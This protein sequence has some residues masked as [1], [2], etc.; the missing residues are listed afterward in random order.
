MK[1]KMMKPLVV[2]GMALWIWGSVASPV[3]ATDLEVF[4]Y[5]PAGN[6]V[7][8]SSPFDPNADDDGDGVTNGQ[9]LI[10]GT[11]PQVPDGGGGEPPEGE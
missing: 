7:R 2:L 6:V 1:D 9:E 8:I 11:D 4:A 5:D 3:L 10:Q